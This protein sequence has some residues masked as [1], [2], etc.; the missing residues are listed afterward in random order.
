MLIVFVN[1]YHIADGDVEFFDGFVIFF[2]RGV[3]DC[4]DKAGFAARASGSSFSLL[5]FLFASGKAGAWHVSVKIEAFKRARDMAAINNIFLHG[6][7]SS[8]YWLLYEKRRVIKIAYNLSIYAASL[9]VK[10]N[11]YFFGAKPRLFAGT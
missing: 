10:G 3:V 6:I 7:L 4:H 5:A 11:L 9:F 8:G 1:N 2:E